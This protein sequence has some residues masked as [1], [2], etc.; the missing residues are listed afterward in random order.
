MAD[1]VVNMTSPGVVDTYQTLWT[2][3]VEATGVCYSYAYNGCCSNGV[4]L[5]I[6]HTDT[7]GGGEST[8]LTSPGNT[9]TC[10]RSATNQSLILSG[11]SRRRITK[12]EVRIKDANLCKEDTPVD[13]KITMDAALTCGGTGCCDTANDHA[14]LL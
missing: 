6:T 5:L 3:D 9:S 12:I 8:T 7:L 10:F 2:G 4:N 1:T 14:E 11:G 13:F